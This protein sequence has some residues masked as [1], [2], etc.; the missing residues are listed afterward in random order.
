MCSL[1][2]TKYL[3]IKV[4]AEDQLVRLLSC[5]PVFTYPPPETESNSMGDIGNNSR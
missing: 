3:I 4:L 2:V 5:E 1:F